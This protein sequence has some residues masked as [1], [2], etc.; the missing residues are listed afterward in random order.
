MGSERIPSKKQVELIKRFYTP[1]LKIIT[2]NKI[3][4]RIIGVTD[5]GLLKVQTK[6]QEVFVLNPHKDKFFILDADRDR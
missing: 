4:G 6:T 1:G 5:T 3:Q 2:K